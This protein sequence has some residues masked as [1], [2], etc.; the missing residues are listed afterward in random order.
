MSA[1]AAAILGVWVF[2]T[3]TWF[4]DG[5]SSLG[6]WVALIVACIVTAAAL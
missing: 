5:I 2:A 3:A 1:E 6:K 4:S